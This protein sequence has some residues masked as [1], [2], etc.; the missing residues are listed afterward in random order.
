MS[1][2]NASRTGRIAVWTG[3]A[4]AW[5]TAVTL[6]SQEAVAD[7]NSTGAQPSVSTESATSGSVPT[8]PDKGLVILRYQPSSD[9]T[10]DPPTVVVRRAAPAP[11]VQAPAPTPAPAPAPRPRS[12]GS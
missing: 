2:F 9:E 1:R 12:G 4:L 8:M 7:A 5:G 3:A 11:R 10:A 6:A